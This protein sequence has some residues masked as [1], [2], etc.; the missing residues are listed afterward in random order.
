MKMKLYNRSKYQVDDF[1]F[2]AATIYSWRIMNSVSN[3]VQY[4]FMWLPCVG[5]VRKR[6]GEKRYASVLL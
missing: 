5:Y 1:R 3:G 4:K 6:E 2:A